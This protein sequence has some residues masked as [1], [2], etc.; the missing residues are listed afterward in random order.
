MQ[1][2]IDESG[3]FALAEQG[4]TI[5][6]VGALVVTDGQLPALERRYAKLRPQL[7][8][9]N[10]EVKGRLMDEASVAR[11]VDLARR[12]GLIFEITVLDMAQN[13]AD[14]IHVHRLA[15]CEGLTKNLTVAHNAKLIADVWALRRRLE[16]LPLQLYAQ[17]MAMFDLV[18]RTFRH[19]AAYYS[20][21]E[22]KALASFRWVVDAKDPSGNTEYEDWWSKVVRPFLQTISIRDPFPEL[23]DGDYSHFV[24]KRMAVPE[25]VVK[26]VQDARGDQAFSMNS[27]FGI[28]FSP[29]TSC[30][31]E[32]VDVLTNAVRR[33]LKGRLGQEGWGGISR[34]MIH[35][36]PPYIQ[37][38]HFADSSGTPPANIAEVIRRL[39]T[40]GRS[41]LT[42]KILLKA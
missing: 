7:P 13:S 12:M 33:A 31:L 42:R 4:S 18:W 20:Q 11:V 21:R 41:M 19:A 37:P 28:E 36:H 40:G 23:E 27:A 39:S 35:R 9:H 2:Y 24:G 29:A 14:N 16:Q 15:Q 5:G 17:S 22:P 32:I 34:L 38:M 8:T 25:H 1:I 10:G 3:T 6:A 30:G 26:Q